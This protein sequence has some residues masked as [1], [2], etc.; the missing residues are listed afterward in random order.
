MKITKTEL[1]QIVK[2]EIERELLEAGQKERQAAADK[3]FAIKTTHWSGTVEDAKRMR[4]ATEKNIADF[5]RSF[6]NDVK[7]KFLEQK[8]IY[9]FLMKKND[10]YW[11]QAYNPNNKHKSSKAEIEK[12]KNLHNEMSL[13]AD[14]VFRNSVKR[15]IRT[16]TDL[17]NALM[18]LSAYEAT[19]GDKSITKI[20]VPPGPSFLSTTFAMTKGAREAN[21]Y[22]HGAHELGKNL[23]TKLKIQI[24]S[25]KSYLEQIEK[26]SEEKGLGPQS[27]PRFSY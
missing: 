25:L 24:E 27:R 11:D 23:H 26:R 22:A 3:E 7:G 9:N 17:S 12:A 18:E 21:L 10:G 4:N 16:M 6:Y 19:L 14:D 13:L 20:L 5:S 15:K 2:E 1:K 8:A